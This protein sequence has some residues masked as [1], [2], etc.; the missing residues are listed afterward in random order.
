MQ[1]T[2]KIPQDHDYDPETGTTRRRLLGGM[3]GAL[4]LGLGPHIRRPEA[5][6]GR[7]SVDG[8]RIMYN[9]APIMLR[10]VSMTDP[11]LGRSWRPV[12]DYDT[13]S[14]W[15]ANF[16]RLSV[17]PST[18]KR[19]RT[20]AM[21]ALNKDVDAALARGMFVMIDWHSIGWP[22][23]W[24]YQ[25]P[26][27]GDKDAFDSN[28]D[29]AKSFWDTVAK[30]W[31]YEGR[32]LFELWNEPV[33]NPNEP[34]NPWQTW[35]QLKN[36]YGQLTGIIRRYSQNIIVAGADKWTSDLRAIKGNLLPD[37]NSIYSWHIYPASWATTQAWHTQLD[38][39]PWVR[40]VVVTEWGF[41]TGCGNDFSCSSAQ[42]YG[43]PFVRDFIM[44]YGM[45]H[46]AWC[47]HTDWAPAML[48]KDWRTTNEFG[49]VVYD[50]L[51]SN[52][53]RRAFF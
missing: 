19:R 51:K 43:I 3:A 15:N 30:R 12:S 26:W 27:G 18:W 1:Q 13:V 42:A 34:G 24:Y 14:S 52:T 38:G 31:G 20:E 40:P 10:G 47:F 37:R 49:R 44:R 8:T 22:G 41:R 46:T 2:P 35:P 23:G 29:L 16:V 36:F 9:G 53:Q 11:L 6:T 50:H 48:Q 21:N 4:A 17:H 33:R 28:F 7:L 39:L 5:A 25:N 45:H 32:I